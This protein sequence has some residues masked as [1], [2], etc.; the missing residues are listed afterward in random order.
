[1]EIKDLPS[2]LDLTVYYN[3]TFGQTIEITDATGAPYDL[4]GKTVTAIIKTKNDK[5]TLLAITCTVTEGTIIL[6]RDISSLVADRVYYW[7]LKINGKVIVAGKFTP[8]S[9]QGY[10]TSEVSL[11]T[12]GATILRLTI[13]QTINE[14][15]TTGTVGLLS[16]T[17]AE[18]LATEGTVNQIFL[19]TD[20]NTAYFWINGEWR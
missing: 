12:T 3:D 1:M 5:T 20:E 14:I 9:K 6:S 19:D 15:S 13:N 7:E 8:S 10:K 11:S 18:R 17:T 2:K 16:G 4:T